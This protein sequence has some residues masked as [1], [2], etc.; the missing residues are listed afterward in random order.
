MESRYIYEFLDI[1]YP[2]GFTSKEVGKSVLEIAVELVV[3]C[4]SLEEVKEKFQELKK[5][6]KIR[7]LLGVLSEKT[8]ELQLWQKTLEE[9]TKLLVDF[10]DTRYKAITEMLQ[11]TFEG[12][13]SQMDGDQQKELIILS[14]MEIAWSVYA[15]FTEAEAKD[16]ISDFKT[17]ILEKYFSSSKE[18]SKFNKRFWERWDEYAEIL[19]PRNENL[20][21]H[22]GEIFC[23]HFFRERVQKADVAR[24]VGM[25]FLSSAK[26]IKKLLEKVNNETKI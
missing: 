5:L 13:Q 1:I 25:S 19:D 10:F 14:M 8:E 24:L 7:E 2:E 9:A 21:L 22:I 20:T 15:V 11:D 26:E 6:N 23:S 12:G 17:I 3:R 16:I 18:K 4:G